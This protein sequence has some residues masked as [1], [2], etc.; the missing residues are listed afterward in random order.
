MRAHKYIRALAFK[1]F[2]RIS[3]LNR[4]MARKTFAGEL[5]YAIA[6]IL[7]VVLIVLPK[8]PSQTVYR[9]NESKSMLLQL[10]KYKYSK[11]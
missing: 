4:L 8:Q 2:K 6:S 9:L 5:Y 10:A 7:D 1:K 11:S 3:S